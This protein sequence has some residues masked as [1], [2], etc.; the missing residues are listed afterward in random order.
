MA[1]N[2]IL[3]VAEKPSIAKSVAQHLAGG[4]INTVGF[5]QYHVQHIFTVQQRNVTGNQYVKNYEFD[6]N[7][8]APWGSCSV[9]MTSVLGHLTALEFPTRYRKWTSCAPL[10]LFDTE[11]LTDVA[12]VSQYIGS[13]RLCSLPIRS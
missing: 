7:F 13:F 1:P 3:C 2:K 6:F 8:G 11:V 12:Q 9:T 10:Q 5:V 4:N